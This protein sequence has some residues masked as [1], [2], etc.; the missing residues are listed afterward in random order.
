MLI[1]AWIDGVQGGESLPGFRDTCAALETCLLFKSILCYLG[2]EGIVAHSLG[3]GVHKVLSI[4][5][6]H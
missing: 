4:A 3:Q 2:G 5:P 1:N 6:I